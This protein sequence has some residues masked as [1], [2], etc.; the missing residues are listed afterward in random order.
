VPSLLSKT[1]E[2]IDRGETLAAAVLL[3]TASGLLF[4]ATGRLAR[5]A[6]TS[7]EQSEIADLV[8]AKVDRVSGRVLLTLPGTSATGRRRPQGR[9]IFINRSSRGHAIADAPHTDP[10]GSPGWPQRGITICSGHA[11][12]AIPADILVTS[13]F[14]GFIDPSRDLHSCY[15]RTIHVFSYLAG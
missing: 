8:A 5:P 6:R 2:L 9:R 7:A 11:G 3:Q 13:V 15:R 12:F 1:E 14:V 4:R 10:T